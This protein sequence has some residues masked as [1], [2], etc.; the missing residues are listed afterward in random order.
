MSIL[1][2]VWTQPRPYIRPDKFYSETTVLDL[3]D[4]EP[5]DYLLLVE[6]RTQGVGPKYTTLPDG[7]VRYYGQSLIDILYQPQPAS[8]PREQQ[9]AEVLA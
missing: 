7:E 5:D 2:T 4:M 6:W 8:D 1:D 3:F 9:R